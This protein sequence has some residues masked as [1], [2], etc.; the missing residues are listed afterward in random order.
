MKSR[1]EVVKTVL[2]LPRGRKR[3]ARKVLPREPRAGASAQ[4]ASLQS[5]P[6]DVAWAQA[7][8]SPNTL[9]LMHRV[10]PSVPV[11]C[12]RLGALDGGVNG[13]SQSNPASLWDHFISQQNSLHL[14]PSMGHRHQ[15]NLDT[16]VPAG[17]MEGWGTYAR[18]L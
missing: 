15:S 3:G 14:A 7:D 10:S 6:A 11:G 12:Y 8:T 9:P 18:G 13:G 1:Q 16:T 2:G 4:P 17:A 5:V